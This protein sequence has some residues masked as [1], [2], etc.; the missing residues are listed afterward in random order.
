[1]TSIRSPRPTCTWPMAA[2]CRPRRSSRRRCARNPERMAIRTKLLEVYAKRRDIKGFELLATQ[3]FSLT[4]GEGEDWA[5]AQ[6]LGAQIDPD[7]PLYQP[8]G[9]P[10]GGVVSAVRSSSRWARARCRSRCCRRRRSSVD[11]DAAAAADSG[12]DVPSTSISTWTSLAARSPSRPPPAPFGSAAS[13]WPTGNGMDFDGCR[14]LS[15]TRLPAPA[16]RGCGDAVGRFRPGRHLARPRPA[17]PRCPRRRR[18]APSAFGESGLSASRRT[19]A[20]GRSA[21]AQAGTGRGVPPDRRHGR[22]ARPAAGSHR[23]G[24][25]HAEVQG[26]GHARRA[27]L[28][29]PVR[30]RRGAACASLEAGVRVALGLSY[31]GQAYHG[32]QSQPGGRTVQD[33]LEQALA[34]SPTGRCARSAPGAPTPAC[35]R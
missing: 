25:R 33:R 6:E 34:R 8:G 4:Q 1:M 30:S 2:T 35:M 5:K 24:S 29:E 14:I 32:W 21:G 27:R 10:A 17:A 16:T 31:R 19:T 12:P 26:P 20:N 7:N 15:P 22:C 9:A 28:I 3:L 18:R 23:Q 13:R 11:V